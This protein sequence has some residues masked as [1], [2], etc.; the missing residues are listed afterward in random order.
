MPMNSDKKGFRYRS[1]FFIGWL[2]SPL[3]PWNDAFINIPISY[4]LAGITERFFHGSFV[5][6]TMVFYWFTNCLG[7]FIMYKSGAALLPNR[8]RIIPE[9]LK[10]I[11]VMAFYSMLIILLYKIGILHPFLPISAQHK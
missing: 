4:V 2:L 5:F 6:M 1:I 9:I 8:S 10:L 7:L 3:T 11:I